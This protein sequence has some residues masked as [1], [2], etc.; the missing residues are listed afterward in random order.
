MP[1]FCAA[2]H[3]EGC[4]PTEAGL[5]M[6]KRAGLAARIRCHGMARLACRRAGCNI[7][8]PPCPS[9]AQFPVQ[10]GLGGA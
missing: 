1:L 5:A 10:A 3:A 9:M 4:R 8:M 2:R 6:I 7:L